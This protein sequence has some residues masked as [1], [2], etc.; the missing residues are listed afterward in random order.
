MQETLYVILYLAK[1]SKARNCHYLNK[2]AL[3]RIL[4]RE[5]AM[6]LISE[7]DL[8]EVHKNKYGTIWDK[9]DE[10]MFQAYGGSFSSLRRR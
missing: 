2:K 5:K 3:G 9:P 7:L 8:V 10:P 6:E 1:S 4:T